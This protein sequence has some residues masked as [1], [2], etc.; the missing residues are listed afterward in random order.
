MADLLQHVRESGFCF[1]DRLIQLFVGG[2]ELHGAREHG[3]DDYLWCFRG[4]SGDGS[5]PRALPHFVWSTA[6]N[7]R[8]NGPNDVAITLYSPKK[9]AGLACKGN[10]TALHFL[11]A[12]GIS[13]NAIWSEVVAKRDLFLARGCAK[14]FLG[15]ADDQLKG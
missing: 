13:G 14:Q 15:F 8:R 6:G 12:E 2:S 4:T 3:T 11:F 5:R 7:D 10:P 1:P 9:W